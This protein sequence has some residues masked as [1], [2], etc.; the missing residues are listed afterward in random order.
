MSIFILNFK[1][2]QKIGKKCQIRGADC[3]HSHSTVKICNK[4]VGTFLLF[5]ASRIMQRSQLTHLPVIET[6][7]VSRKLPVLIA[8][9]VTAILA[10]CG[11]AKT[12]INAPKQ[13]PQIEE[14]SNILITPIWKKKHKISKR[15][16]F[17]PT[18]LVQNDS[19]FTA[20]SKVLFALNKNTGKSIW[21]K[22]FGINLT[23][24]VSGDETALFVADEHP[25]VFAINTE[26]GEEI[27]RV[28][29]QSEVAATIA[30][31][32]KLIVAKLVNGSIIALDRTN[33]DQLWQYKT[34][35]PELMVV[36]SSA[37]VI[38]YG[39]TYSSL[40]NGNVIAINNELGIP[41]WIQRVNFPTGTS[42]IERLID[43][44]VTPIIKSGKLISTGYN[45]NIVAIETR[46]G[47]LLWHHSNS[48][49]KNMHSHRGMVAT[50]NE[51]SKIAVYNLNNGTLIW[52]SEELL[53]RK[54]SN[55]IITN[56]YIYVLDY[57]GFLSTFNRRN[58]QLLAT[59]KVAKSATIN[60]IVFSDQH[61]YFNT[62]KGK[63]LALAISL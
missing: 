19:L 57:K 40:D 58:G 47:K 45:G 23:A 15:H 2:G 6:N 55:P 21:Q 1:N 44:D 4:E 59:N 5:F 51:K 53:N 26:N 46:T 3:E 60:N 34:E 20:S 43:L 33:G 22:D 7:Y 16:F 61:L 39:V 28:N 29:L 49:S 14:N 32:K 9:I 13:L 52:E 31:D 38:E 8:V 12:K 62:Q 17:K 30:F 27:W 35:N 50:V 42:E 54:L 10:S 37:P 25:R 11:S 63:L 36:G 41:A 48:S 24:A 56:S 18:I